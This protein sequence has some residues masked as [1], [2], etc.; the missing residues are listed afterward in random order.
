MPTPLLP[1][2]RPALVARCWRCAFESRGGGSVLQLGVWVRLGV[3]VS[4]VRLPA[5]LQVC[6]SM[7][8]V[9]RACERARVSSLLSCAVNSRAAP[10]LHLSLKNC[11]FVCARALCV[12]SAC[13][14]AGVNLCASVYARACES[15]SAAAAAA[16]A[17]S[18]SS[19]SLSISLSQKKTSLSLIS[20]TPPR[21]AP[22]P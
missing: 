11:K 12:L 7:R 1:R 13:L 16:A 6:A 2:C 14:P 22:S 8:F 20:F 4:V 3:C 18:L 21:G 5:C 9:R 19:S 10:R 15:E 17:R